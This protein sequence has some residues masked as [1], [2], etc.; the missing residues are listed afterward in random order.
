[1]SETI[2]MNVGIALAEVPINKQPLVDDT[3]FKTLEGLLAYNAPGLELRWIFFE[4]DGTKTVTQVVPTSGGLHDWGADSDTATYTIEI[5]AAGGTINNDTVGHGYFMGI[6]TGVYPWTGPIIEFAEPEAGF[7]ARTVVITV[8]DGDAPPVPIQG[9]RVRVTEGANT[10]VRTTDVNG[11]VTFF[12]DDATWSVAITKSGYDF[13]GADLVVDG[14]EAETYSMT[15]TAP[16]ASGSPDT[17]TAYCHAID[18]NGPVQDI[19]CTARLKDIV[20]GTGRALVPTLQ[21]ADTDVDG[22]FSFL[23][24]KGGSYE[25][26]LNGRTYREMIPIDASDPYPVGDRIAGQ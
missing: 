23:A 10:R 24:H 3:D 20:T 13:A 14:N 11:Q 25:L 4:A 16:P 17:V 15:S 19:P 21:E 9:A 2:S 5:P 22:L 1:M 6:A 12:L 8:D 26:N 18:E 7:G